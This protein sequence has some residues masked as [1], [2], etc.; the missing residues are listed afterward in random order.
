MAKHCPSR[1]VP[2]GASVVLLA[3][4][5]T[6]HAELTGNVG[7]SNNYIWRGVT[8]T[9]DEPAVSG[10]IDYAHESGFYAGTWISNVD[11]S[12]TTTASDSSPASKNEIE[13]DWYVGYGGAVSDFSYDLG[14]ALFTY[15]LSD[16][17]DFGE[18]YGSVGYSYLSVG[19]AY[20]VNSQ[21]E[22]E[23]QFMEG[24]LYYSATLDIPIAG[25]FGVSATYGHYEFDE[26]SDASYDHY[27]LY[28]TKG[29]F[30]FGVEKNDQDGEYPAG[31]DADDPRVVVS[32]SHSTDLL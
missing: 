20:T 4:A 26:V 30:S 12:D 15:P 19:A 11:F 18:V 28:L 3:G 10:G 22:G 31:K 23:S 13:Q 24:D 6:A 14:Y 27:N 8:Q 29:N 21:V 25:D 9:N 32:W 16:N 7:V 5:A 1:F 17:A 2:F